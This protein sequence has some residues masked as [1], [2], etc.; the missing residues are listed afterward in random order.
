MKRQILDNR[1]NNYWAIVPART[2]YFKEIK[3]DFSVLV[4]LYVCE[5]VQF[6]C[7]VDLLK[8]PKI[9]TIKNPL[10]GEDR[11]LKLLWL[12]DVS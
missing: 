4:V 7:R 10:E 3:N 9:P 12:G 2:A 6:V 11:P 5:G 8:N 1:S